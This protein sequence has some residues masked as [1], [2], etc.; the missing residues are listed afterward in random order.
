[1]DV[2]ALSEDE[3]SAHIKRLNPKC[4]IKFDPDAWLNDGRLMWVVRSEPKEARQDDLTLVRLYEEE[5][6]RWR[7]KT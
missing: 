5:A 2:A 6:R 7:A 1:M 4:E 3:I